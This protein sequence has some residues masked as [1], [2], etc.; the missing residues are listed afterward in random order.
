MNILYVSDCIP[1]DGIP[2]AGGKTF[3]YYIKRMADRHSDKITIVGLCKQEDK[4]KFD[5]VHYGIDC[6]PICSRGS[7][8]TNIVRISFDIFGNLFKMHSL[9]DSF[10][11]EYYIIKQLK[12][13]KKNG[14]KPDIIQLEWTNIVLLVSSIKKVFPEAA[15]IASEHDV[16]FLRAERR[17]KQAKHSRKNKYK[18]I[19]IKQKEKELNAL[20]QC[21]IIMPHN[22]KD[23]NLLVNNGIS[24]EK[25]HVLTPYFHNMSYIQRNNLT[26]DVLFWGAMYR[27]DNYEAVIWF[28]DN[29]MPL[30]SDLDIRFIVAGNK[31]PKKLIEMASDKIIITGFVDDE[32]PF[33]EHSLCFVS[34]LLTGAG[35]KV[36]VIEAMSAGIPILTNTIGIEGI[37]AEDGK[38]YFHCEKP[39]EY[40]VI[41]R[42]LIS[43]ELDEIKIES[44][45]HDLICSSFNLEKSF[46]EYILLLNDLVKHT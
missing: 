32:T 36:K 20:G 40:A 42:K 19:W 8:K 23:K 9:E 6:Y 22:F 31:P 46:Q 18:K 38:S 1:Y 39:E 2:H 11:K 24:D 17:Y 27:S 14:L 37:P 41:I 16:S 7:I 10:F 29:V 43:G 13:L 44:N 45:E 25:I 35:I 33:F 26:H 34:P 21:D 12:I 30:L 3:N 5:L 15:V 28:I 4:K